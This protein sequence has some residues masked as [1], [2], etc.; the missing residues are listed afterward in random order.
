MSSLFE[1]LA[2]VPFTRQW[3]IRVWRAPRVKFFA[4][5]PLVI[6]RPDAIRAQQMRVQKEAS[7]FREP[8]M[9]IR[10]VNASLT[11]SKDL[12]TWSDE[13]E[14][15]Y[16]DDKLA[17]THKPGEGHTDG[18]ANLADFDESR[19]F[20]DQIGI[21]DRL[22]K[23]CNTFSKFFLDPNRPYWSASHSSFYVIVSVRGVSNPHGAL[24]LLSKIFSIVVYIVGTAMFASSTL[25]TVPVAIVVASLVVIAAVFSRIIAMC[26][27]SGLPHLWPR[28]TS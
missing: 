1:N 2:G 23:G 12:P 5:A 25:A 14:V 8:E 10:A 16:H 9:R 21:L 15:A 4:G 22:E 19:V 13:A 17:Q 20:S 18:D 26:K 24:R 6:K 3:S 7:E 27:G 28:L 11:N